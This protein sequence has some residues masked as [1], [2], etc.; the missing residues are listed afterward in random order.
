MRFVPR[1][2]AFRPKTMPPVAHDN[3]LKG[4]KR[5]KGIWPRNG[6]L[7]LLTWQ[8][9]YLSQGEGMDGAQISA[10]LGLPRH[11]VRRHLAAAVAALAS[12]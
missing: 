2:R 3:D 10:F 5:P 11:V 12:R 1:F 4:K 9:L 8:I 6:A 7:P